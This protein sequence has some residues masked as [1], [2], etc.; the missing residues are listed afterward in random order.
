MT[1][2]EVVV[3]CVMVGVCGVGVFALVRQWLRRR[4]R[5]EG[6]VAVQWLPQADGAEAFTVF[7]VAVFAVLATY[8]LAPAICAVAATWITGGLDLELVPVRAISANAML[9]LTII[10]AAA[11]LLVLDVV[12]RIFCGNNAHFLNGY[13]KPRAAAVPNAAAPAALGGFDAWGPF[14]CF[15]GTLALTLPLSAGIKELGEWLER[16]YGNSWGLT[17]P[18][19]LVALF[20]Q[21]HDKPLFA[22]LIFVSVCIAAPL[23]EEVFFRGIL[24]P[25]FKRLAGIWPAA[26]LTG[27]LFGAAHLSTAAFLPLTV[28]G[29]YLCIVYEKNGNLA[30][31]ISVHARFNALSLLM[32]TLEQLLSAKPA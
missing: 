17:E 9:A 31:P 26:I 15:L 23:V 4:E 24:Y 1:Y 8:F 6:A 3:A 25:Y 14:A 13:F 27:V 19:E 18:Q 2:T 16:T 10:A 29:V 12:R 20:T 22:V 32:L 11:V 21:N 5:A 7:A 28:L 30:A